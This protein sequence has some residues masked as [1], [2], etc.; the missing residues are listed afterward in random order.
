MV[1]SWRNVALLEPE[2]AGTAGAP[3][4]PGTNG[5]G[6]TIVGLPPELGEVKNGTRSS[7]VR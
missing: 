1:H 6:T 7:G 5:T 3:G 2:V 4:M